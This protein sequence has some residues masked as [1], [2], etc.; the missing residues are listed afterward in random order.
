MEVVVLI[1]Q[2]DEQT[3]RAETAQPIALVTQ[4]R[5]RDEAIER[6][7]SLARQ[8]LA[9][10]EVLHVEIPEVAAPHPW[11]PFAGIWKDHPDF[12]AVLEHIADE[13][14]R[15]DAAESEP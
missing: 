1:E 4:G 6:L 10:G 13:R 5:T 12:D 11:L 14:R 7:R 2:L 8:R 9:A 3:Y 15:R